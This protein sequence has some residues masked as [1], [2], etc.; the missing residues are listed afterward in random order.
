LI[1]LNP[2]RLTN[3]LLVA[4]LTSTAAEFSTV[5]VWAGLDS[6]NPKLK[7]LYRL[8]YTLWAAA[9]PKLKSMARGPSP[10]LSPHLVYDFMLKMGYLKLRPT[11]RESDNH[12]DAAQLSV[13]PAEMKAPLV[14]EKE[15]NGS[16]ANET[17]PSPSNLIRSLFF[18]SGA[19]YAAD[20]YLGEWCASLEVV[21]KLTHTT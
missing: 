3:Y 2:V 6:H 4:G 21:V 9:V 11:K 17:S 8:Q 13:K 18:S 5:E 10:A 1:R 14:Q 16:A 15:T 20:L 19:T 12:V 7:R